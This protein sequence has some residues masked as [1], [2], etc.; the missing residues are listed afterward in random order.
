MFGLLKRNRKE[1]S[2]FLELLETAAT[3][4]NL[5]RALQEHL[6]ACGDCRAAADEMAAT[7]EL[8]KLP[9]EAATPRPWFA[10][11]VMAAIAAREAEL[12]RS[13]DAWVVVPRLASKLTWASAFALLLAS[14][15]LYTRPVSVPS[16]PVL[17]DITG[18]PVWENQPQVSIDDV[19]V[20][21]NERVQ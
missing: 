20:S 9:R 5:P 3:L 4:E 7:R 17:T 1:C 12:R 13:L 18:E 8:L 14:T 2:P 19:L 11:R 15:W 21:M 16:R 6:S 10:P